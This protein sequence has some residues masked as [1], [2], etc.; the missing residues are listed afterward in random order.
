MTSTDDE[1]SYMPVPERGPA[2]ITDFDGVRVWIADNDARTRAQ[3]SEQ[4]RT[5]KRHADQHEKM[6]VRVTAFEKRLFWIIAITSTISSCIG[7]IIGQV[8]TKVAH[9]PSPPG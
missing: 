9:L 5:N 3:W 1:G 7:G 8:L 2:H 4:W 6:G